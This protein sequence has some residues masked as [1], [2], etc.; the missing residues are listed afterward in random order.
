M[1]NPPEGYKPFNLERALA[2]DPVKS[3]DGRPVTQLTLFVT[4]DREY[5][6]GV[7]NDEVKWWKPTGRYWG[8]EDCIYDLFM[9]SSKKRTVW[10]NL[11]PEPGT[12]LIA[13]AHAFED[14]D[15]ADKESG[16]NRLGNRAYP[17]EIEE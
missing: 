8:G 16:P 17:V 11:Y 4:S 13:Y 7:I 10:V 2:G 6:A 9:T 3:R 14:K 15:E 5:L 1:N 12:R